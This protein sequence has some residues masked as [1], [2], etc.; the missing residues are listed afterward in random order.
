MHVC[1]WSLDVLVEWGVLEE[2]GNTLSVMGA[3]AGLGE[4]YQII[5]KQSP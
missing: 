2:E 5:S 3:A 4:L 1:A